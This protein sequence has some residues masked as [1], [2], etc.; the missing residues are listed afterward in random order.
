MGMPMGGGGGH[1]RG[2][3]RSVRACLRWPG[4]CPGARVPMPRCRR[5]DCDVP[6]AV[7]VGVVEQRKPEPAR[8]HNQIVIS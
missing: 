2:S 3:S 7:S 8:L 5:G 6:A 4:A 1:V